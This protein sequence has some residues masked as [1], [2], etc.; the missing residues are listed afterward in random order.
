[1]DRTLAGTICDRE[2]YLD[3]KCPDEHVVTPD[4]AFIKPAPWWDADRITTLLPG[5]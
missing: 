2:L 5:A 1:M 4:G 3:P